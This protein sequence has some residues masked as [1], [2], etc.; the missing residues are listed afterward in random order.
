[1][2]APSVDNLVESFENPHIPLI[3]VEPTYTMLHGM[4]KLLN[5]KAASVATNLGCGSL[6]HFFLTLSPTFYATLSTTRVIPPLNPGATPV[7]PAVATG[8]DAASI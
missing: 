5:S 8:P 6:V 3:D 1:M 7:I 4:H 2:A